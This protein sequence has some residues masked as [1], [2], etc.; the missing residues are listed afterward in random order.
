MRL[1]DDT[2]KN[3]HRHGD[4]AGA[5]HHAV[6]DGD[7]VVHGADFPGV[8]AHR[9]E[10]GLHAVAQV[11]E[12]HQDGQDVERRAPYVAEP[13]DNHPVNVECL[14]VAVGDVGDVLCGIIADA[15][16]VLVEMVD[17]EHQDGQAGVDHVAGGERRL[18]RVLEHI[19]FT[20]RVVLQ[21]QLDGQP[22]V[23]DEDHRKAQAD[24]PQGGFRHGVQAV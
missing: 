6:S 23:D 17:Q 8:K 10:D 2:Q 11:A 20:G 5:D 18:D 12:E 15:Q 7:E 14:H 22:D 19:G 4:E 16:G 9:L 1:F 21:L 13:V 3:R 24:A